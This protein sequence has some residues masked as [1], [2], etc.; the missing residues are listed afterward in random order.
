MCPPA[1]SAGLRRQRGSRSLSAS[2]KIHSLARGDQVPRRLPCTRRH[3]QGARSGQVR[4]RLPWTTPRHVPYTRPPTLHPPISPAGRQRGARSGQVRAPTQS[5]RYPTPRSLPYTL[6][7]PTLYPPTG[8]SARRSPRPSPTPL[9]LHPTRRHAQ[10]ARRLPYMRLPYRR[11]AGPRVTTKSRAAYPGPPAPED[12][13]A[14]AAA[15]RQVD[16]RQVDRRQVDRRQVDHR[17]PYTTSRWRRRGPRAPFAVSLFSLCLCPL[18]QVAPPSRGGRIGEIKANL[19]AYPQQIV[20][21][22]LLYCLQDRLRTAKSSANDL[23]PPWLK[24]QYANYRDAL[25]APRY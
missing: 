6:P 7:P 19:T 1:L 15:R 8:A 24:L 12:G 17:L 4:R 10:G 18:H 3:A 2:R 22:R 14:D 13:R 23:T 5:P 9:T 11:R 21:T 20:T 16:R 25:R